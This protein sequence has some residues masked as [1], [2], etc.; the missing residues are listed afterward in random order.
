[1]GNLFF[2]RQYRLTAGVAGEV[3]FTVGEPTPPHNSPLH[4][5]FSVERTDSQTLNTSKITLWNLTQE[6]INTLMRDGCQVV[7]NAGYG[8]GRPCIFKGTVTNVNTD[9]D[10]AD[11][12]TE[13]ETVDGFGEL[14]DTYISLSYRGKVSA[15]TIIDA[16]AK[17]LGISVVYSKTARTMALQAN[18]S[19]GYSYVGA[20]KN[21]L[22]KA[23]RLAKITWAIQNG[24][25]QVYKTG[26]TVSNTVHKLT[27]ETGLIGVPRKIYNSAVASGEDT[28]SSLQD[29][30]FGYEVTY[31]MN[32]NINVNDLVKIESKIVTGLFRVYKLQIDGDNLEGDWQCTAQVVEVNSI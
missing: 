9:L 2:D 20:V 6:H 7:L 27:P 24:V 11:R 25:L 22:L 10:G 14:K 15:Y 18:L 21:A 13:I 1:M 30:L 32:G 28:G 12:A 31:F 19:S 16:C 8:T 29:S 26:E 4:I 3:G 5:S 23:C 17:N